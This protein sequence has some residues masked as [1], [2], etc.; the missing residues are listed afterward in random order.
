MT[1]TKLMKR[2][3]AFLPVGMSLAALGLVMGHLAL[4]GVTRGGDEGTAAHLFQLLMAS[5]LPIMAFFAIRWLPQA[6]RSAFGVLLLQIA[7]AVAALAPI[8]L[9]EM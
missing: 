4:Y 1:F 9:L 7:A 3:S 2:P 6:P 5:Q 8:F